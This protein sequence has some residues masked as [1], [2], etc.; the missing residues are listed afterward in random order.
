MF[1]E[2]RDINQIRLNADAKKLIY[3]YLI[4]KEAKRK[5]K[6]EKS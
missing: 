2:K 4:V 6:V 1:P 3:F 5:R